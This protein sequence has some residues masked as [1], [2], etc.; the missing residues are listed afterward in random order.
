MA[1]PD[2]QAYPCR[3]MRR[4]LWALLMVALLS[5]CTTSSL[6]DLSRGRPGG[7]GR[8]VADSGSGSGAQRDGSEAPTGAGGG[9]GVDLCSSG[10]LDGDETDVDCGGTL[11]AP[12]ALGG[13]CR[14]DS[15]CANQSCSEGVCR[16]T[17]CANRKGDGSGTDRDCG[18]GA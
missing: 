2:R 11:C 16:R 7:G 4:A 8:P 1:T 3:S 18:G 14:A 10:A 13:A 6:D 9:L 15:D 17:G 5:A 12:C